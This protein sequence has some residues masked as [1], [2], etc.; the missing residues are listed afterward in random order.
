MK[1]SKILFAV[2]LSSE[3]IL[4]A[5]TKPTDS[6]KPTELNEVVVTAQFA[7]ITEKNAIYKVKVISQKTI[8]AQVASSL[9]DL[10]R[11]ELNIDLS[12]SPIFGAGVELHG[13]SK[14]NIKILMDGV[15]IIGRVNGVLNLNQINLDNIE[16]IEV[17]EGPVSVFYGT[18]ALGGTINLISKKKLKKI[19][20]GLFNFKYETVEARDVNGSVATKLG[21][22]LIR[23]EVGK[24][25]FNGLNTDEDLIR[26]LNWPTKNQYHT[27]LKYIRDFGN[28]KLR[29]SSALSEEK[30]NTLGEVRAS[31]QKA[32]D[33]DYTT[34]RW[35]NSLN[36]QGKFNQDKYL[37][38]TASYLDYDRSDKTY[39]Y[40]ATTNS[41]ALIE[42]NPQEN[43]NFFDTYFAKV[44]FAKSNVSD[45]LNYVVGVEYQSDKG[46][47]NR[48]LNEEQTVANTSVFA[49]LNYKIF[50]NLEVQPAVRYTNNSDFGDLFSPALNLKYKLNNHNVFRFAYANG[51]RAP[52][53]K[54][55]YLDWSPTFGP[56]TYTFSGNEDLKVESSHHF[57]IHYNYTKQFS[58]HSSLEIEPAVFYN[59]VKDLI[60]LSE[61]VAFKRHYINL[62][63]T[64]TFSSVVRAKYHVT[65]NL[66]IHLGV[67]YLGRYLE[68]N[69]EFDSDGFMFTPAVN[70]SIMYNYK[71]FNLSFNAFYKFTGE[72]EGH[73]IDDTSGTD[74]LISTTRDSFSNLDISISKALLNKQLSIS[75]GAKNIF[76]VTNL[77]TF[78][79]IGVAHER[80]IQLWGASY[81]I[82]TK[83]RF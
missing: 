70:A 33:I 20:E 71:P 30:V 3:A 57:N 7:P 48:I 47:G 41:A 10:L 9:T 50:D 49:S 40:N 43:G 36:F 8:E 42:N 21:K 76:D 64:K 55:L 15:P 38:I 83:F 2:L 60:G 54:E 81:F 65:E 51:Y 17:I 66:N 74:E 11:Q 46:E 80:D 32:K 37:D 27:N 44:Q 63:K 78:N 13:I 82:Q 59:E 1:F 77:E 53:I 31:T 6:I 72:E 23:L 5:Q 18:D 25:S 39:V 16:R 67:S 75:V 69:D 35:D 24:Y 56:F 19:F 29:L 58:N 52:S 68:Y 73:Y 79:Q 62:N 26:T 34:R 22:N 4:S 12:F 28:F 61:M 14:E 45:K